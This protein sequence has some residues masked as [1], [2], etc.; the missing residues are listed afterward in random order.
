[1]SALPTIIIL[2]TAE[3]GTPPDAPKSGVPVSFI[4]RQELAGGSEG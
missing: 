3:H 2:T 4:V 1:M